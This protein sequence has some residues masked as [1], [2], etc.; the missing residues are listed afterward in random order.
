MEQQR[1]GE[2]EGAR[3]GEGARNVPYAI[4]GDRT[5]PLSPSGTG[6]SV[7]GTGSRSCS[8]STN[9]TTSTRVSTQ[10]TQRH[11]QRQRRSTH[12]ALAV[13]G[14]GDLGLRVDH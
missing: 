14:G 1:C 2:R 6:S 3:K 8:S 4:A 12:H 13:E 9:N 10:R 11:L 7:S 5:S